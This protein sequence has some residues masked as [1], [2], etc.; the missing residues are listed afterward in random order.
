MRHYF[1]NIR[2]F[3]ASPGDVQTERKR[4]DGIVE[5]VNNL[6]GNYTGLKFEV[7][8]WEKNAVSE[9]GR[10]Q[11]VINR[12]LNLKECD[13]FLG[14]L[15]CRFGSPTGGINKEGIKYESGTEEEFEL[16]YQGWCE[17]E[18]PSVM[19]FKCTRKV[20]THNLDISQYKKV[21]DFFSKFN[22]DNEHPGLI[23]EYKAGKEFETKLRKA[24][25]S[26]AFNLSD[27]NDIYDSNNVNLSKCFKNWGYER[28]FL[29][30]MNGKRDDR[31]KEVLKKAKI[32][33]LVS[34]A[35]YS[36]VSH[37]GNIFREIIEERLK[38]GCEFKIIL[39]NPWS[40]IGAL[41]STSSVDGNNLSRNIEKDSHGL[42]K[43]KQPLELIENSEW[44]QIKHRDSISGYKELKQKY[45][46][47]ELRISRY[48][49]LASV[50]IVDNECFVEPYLG[51][52]MLDRQEKDMLTFE[53]NINSRSDL[54]NYLQDYFELIWSLSD[55]YAV[56]EKNILEYKR[57]LETQN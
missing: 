1:Q 30:P 56:Y 23:V 48:F 6:I 47:I 2:V 21:E 14:I 18:K 51:L 45:D 57:K 22:F 37:F 9:M 35:G 38:S 16:A 5:E 27:N 49:I 17:C 3:I 10:P 39:T 34:H 50:L 19:F 42:I 20:D 46:N 7:V 40:E 55:E 41:V 8:K 32:I 33:K 26:H 31:K 4:I 52:N 28:L 43:F 25:V 53:M 44:Y 15:W 24:L 29:P 13:L 12:Q 54:Y 36:F 11:E